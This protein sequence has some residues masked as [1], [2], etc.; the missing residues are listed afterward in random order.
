M[1][2]LGS[3]LPPIVGLLLA[4]LY[5]G[6]TFRLPLESRIFP[7]TVLAPVVGLGLVLLVRAIREGEVADEQL[8]PIWRSRAPLVFGLSVAFVV[9]FALSNF[10][11]AAFLF[12][13]VSLLVLKVR[14]PTALLTAVGVVAGYYLIFAKLLGMSL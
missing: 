2:R 1:A 6:T 5:Y 14:W 7:Q 4:A 3:V 11:I 12:L 10:L 9:L 13:L 8:V